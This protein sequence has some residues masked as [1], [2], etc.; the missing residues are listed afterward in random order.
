MNI[1]V[2][3]IVCIC[4]GV[5]SCDHLS[6][7]TEVLFVLITEAA[8]CEPGGQLELFL[9]THLHSYWVK[10]KQISSKLYSKYLMA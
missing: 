8:L 9:G 4:S 10:N 1:I 3:Q 7:V 5:K 2:P 6:A